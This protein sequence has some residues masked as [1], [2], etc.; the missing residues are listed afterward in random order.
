MSFLDKLFKFKKKP[1]QGPITQSPVSGLPQTAKS[2]EP[3][4]GSREPI[5]E[6]SGIA[7]RVL[8]RALVTEKSTRM[9]AEN[10]Y[11]FAVPRETTKGQVKE[12]VRALY[13]IMPAS[14]NMVRVRGK[15]MRFGRHRG[16]EKDWKKAM[17]TLP[18]GKSIS[19]VNRN[20]SS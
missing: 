8:L 16:Q 2:A 17:V 7:P 9:G 5:T 12:A 1:R 15:D 13:G 6:T 18:L 20:E 14:V 11:V 3:Q 10:A 19:I 4:A